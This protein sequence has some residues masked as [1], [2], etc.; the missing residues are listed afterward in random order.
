MNRFLGIVVDSKSKT[1]TNHSE[2]QAFVVKVIKLDDTRRMEDGFIKA[3]KAEVEGL[4]KHRICRKIK[5]S[6]VL[7]GEIILGGRFDMTLRNYSTSSEAAKERYV[8]Q[9]FND[10]DKELIVHST[11]IIRISPI[12]LVLSASSV[13]TVRILSQDVTQAFCQSK[14]KL[15]RKIYFCPNL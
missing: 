3:K 5:R 14:D 7:A 2:I 12:R 13:L 4:L 15:T 6:G 1:E 10:P 11:E 9:G 8:A